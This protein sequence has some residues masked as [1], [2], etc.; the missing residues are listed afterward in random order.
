MTA[1]GLS[2]RV[3]RVTLGA[4]VCGVLLLGCN[5]ES[6]PPRAEVTGTVTLDGEPVQGAIVEFTPEVEG[7]TTSYGGT[8]ASGHYRMLF[9]TDRTGVAIGR[10][11]VRITT[12]DRAHVGGQEYVSTELF[13]AKYN[14]KTELYRDVIEGDNILDFELESGNTKP[15]RL[16]TGGGS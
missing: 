16:N 15:R 3:A 13:P 9:G 14:S 12:D 2:G 8:D 5:A 6:G 7:A 4:A 1:T 10:N 11:R